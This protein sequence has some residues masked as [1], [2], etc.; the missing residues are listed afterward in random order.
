[1]ARLSWLLAA[2]VLAACAT[3]QPRASTDEVAFVIV[4]HAEKADAV[5][6]DPALSAAG[7]ERAASLARRLAGANVVA[8]YTTGF[9]RTRDTVAP[10]ATAQGLAATVYDA[11]EPAT[12]LV[13]R[14]KAAHRE[15]TVLVAGHSNTV[16]DIVA[17]LCSCDVAAMTETEFD[18]TSTVRIDARGRARL[19]TGRY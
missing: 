7:R 8:I 4:R 14:L 13:A 18:R 6:G 10:T 9:R 2:L 19:E 5:G 1:M 16:P 17:A 12:I 15:G 3:P 11:D